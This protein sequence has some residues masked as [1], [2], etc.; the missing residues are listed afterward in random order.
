M[1][2]IEGFNR[3]APR[4]AGGAIDAEDQQSLAQLAEEQTKRDVVMNLCRVPSGNSD[5]VL[6]C[7]FAGMGE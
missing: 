7:F 6:N 4:A 2:C 1:I 3:L 5:A